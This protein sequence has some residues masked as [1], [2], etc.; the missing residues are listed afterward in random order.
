MKLYPRMSERPPEI[1]INR[2]SPLWA[3]LKLFALFDY[4]GNII[5]ASPNAFNISRINFTNGTA[6]KFSVD[7]RRPCFMFTGNGDYL[8]VIRNSALEPSDQLTVCVFAKPFTTVGYRDMIRKQADNSNGYILR[9]NW[10]GR[11]TLIATDTTGIKYIQ[12]T[13]SV[14]NY[15][16]KWTMI[17]GT[18]KKDHEGALYVNG[19]KKTSIAWPNPIIHADDLYIATERFSSHFYGELTDVMVFARALS[20]SEIA[21]LADPGNVDLRVGGIPLILPP[22]RRSWPGITITTQ[23]EVI[24]LPTLLAEC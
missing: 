11:I 9:L 15:E 24:T 13:D 5:D 12:D 20:S 1:R 3:D 19:I 8:K 16:N 2:S 7:L 21:Q 10:G 14:V 18:I 4:N 22:R 23:D 17:V 6:A